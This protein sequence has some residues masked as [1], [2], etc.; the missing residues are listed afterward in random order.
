MKMV[1]VRVRVVVTM[2]MRV[3]MIM[4][5]LRLWLDDVLPRTKHLIDCINGL[6]TIVGVVS[7]HAYVLD[8]SLVNAAVVFREIQN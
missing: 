3:R 7:L 1:V 8:S 6:P 5:C 2:S 4:T